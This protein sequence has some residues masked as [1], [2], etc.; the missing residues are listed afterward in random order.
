MVDAN[1]DVASECIE[2]FNRLKMEKNLRYVTFKIENQRT[3]VTDKVRGLD[4]QASHLAHDLPH[5]EPRFIIMD[6]EHVN[7]DGLVLNK[8]IFIHWC[9]DVSRVNLKM[10][11]AS[12]KENFRKKM[13]GIFKELQ[14]STPDDLTVASINQ[15]IRT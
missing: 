13:V 14:A 4:H 11:Y 5:D 7:N 9:P 8:I 2:L 12:T 1:L 6:Y 10:V 3:V 15:S